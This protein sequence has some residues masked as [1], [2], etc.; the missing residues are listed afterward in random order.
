MPSRRTVMEWLVAA[1]VLALGVPAAAWLLQERMIFLPQP[2]AATAP[3]P[4][5]AVPWAITV[6]HN[7]VLHGWIAHGTE[8]PAPAILYFGG[9]AEEVSWTLA[10]ARWPRAWTIV[11]LNYRGYGASEGAPGEAAL[12]SDAL[13]IYDA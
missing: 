10:D 4:A 5:H 1:V 13:A 12:S 2:G 7:T 6:S 8:V 9:N 3:L 11:G